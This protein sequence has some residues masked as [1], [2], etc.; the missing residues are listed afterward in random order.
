MSKTEIDAK[1]EYQ[2]TIGEVNSGGHQPIRFTRVKYKASHNTH[3]DIRQ[4]QR[5]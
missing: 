4:Y 5:G 1:I 3:I 2:K